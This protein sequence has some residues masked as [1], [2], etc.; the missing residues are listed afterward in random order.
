MAQLAISREPIDRHD[1]S[2]APPLLVDPHPLHV[3][4]CG[5]LGVVRGWFFLGVLL[6]HPPLTSI[7]EGESMSSPVGSTAT[8]VRD[9]GICSW[10]KSL[11][12]MLIPSW[13]RSTT[14]D[15]PACRGA[16]L[17]A[18]FAGLMGRRQQVFRA[19]RPHPDRPRSPCHRHRSLCHHPAS[20]IRLQF[21]VL[22]GYAPGSGL[23]VVTDPRRAHVSDAGRADGPGGSDAPR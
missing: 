11:P 9:Y 10:A 15:H 21:R 20:G 17:L 4:T 7:Y 3:P 16:L 23:P 2:P 14:G 5:D 22:P 6:R 19:V 8:S 1:S 13:L 18:G 12:A